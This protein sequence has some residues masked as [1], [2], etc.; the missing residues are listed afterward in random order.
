MDTKKGENMNRQDW[1]EAM[2]MIDDDLLSEAAE[3]FAGRHKKK[4][5]QRFFAGLAAAVIMLGTAYT[6]I[7]IYNDHMLPAGPSDENVALNQGDIET[8]SAFQKDSSA[9]L[10][11]TGGFTE[12][13]NTS[14]ADKKAVMPTGVTKKTE[15]SLEETNDPEI[16]DQAQNVFLKAD[17]KIYIG[18]KVT[19]PA[20]SCALPEDAVLKGVADIVEGLPEEQYEMSNVDIGTLIYYSKSADSYFYYYYGNVGRLHLATDYEV[21]ISVC[22]K[23]DSCL[24]K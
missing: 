8:T 1:D 12:K 13:I 22:F 4:K 19:N 5:R 15:S 11:S 10:S 16:M 7:S 18:Q 9:E 2:L 21:E 20:D 24:L 14:E 17:E 3:A 6:V 23:K